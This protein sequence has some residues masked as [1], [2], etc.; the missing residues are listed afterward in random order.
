M[1]CGVGLMSRPWPAF[2][3]GRSACWRG[4]ITMTMCPGRMRRSSCRSRGCP[5]VA[6]PC[7]WNTSASTGT[8]ATPSRRGSGWARRSD[9]TPGQFAEL[10]RASDL[11]LLG[12]P[13]WV[14]PKDGKLTIRFTLPRQAV[15][16]LV[17]DS[18]GR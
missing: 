14:R 8:T 13:E 1:A 17:L 16:L 3:I 5:M 12:S 11:T 10:Q 9:P 6:A 18:G 7:S 15:S 4:T 2:G